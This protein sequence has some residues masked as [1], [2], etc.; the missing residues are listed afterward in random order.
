V[1]HEVF[2]YIQKYGLYQQ[3]PGGGGHAGA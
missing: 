1:P 3:A 2:S